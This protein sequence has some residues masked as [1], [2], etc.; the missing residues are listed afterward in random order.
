MINNEELTTKLNDLFIRTESQNN[1]TWKDSSFLSDLLYA[2]PNILLNDSFFTAIY[3]IVFIFGMHSDYYYGLIYAIIDASRRLHCTQMIAKMYEGVLQGIESVTKY[4]T[5]NV[6]RNINIA[7]KGVTELISQKENLLAGKLCLLLGKN[8]N[9]EK[10]DR[11]FYC[12]MAIR[13]LDE[14][15][16]EYET[17]V[18]LKNCF[19]KI[20]T[21]PC[22][23]I[24][25]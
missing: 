4:P 18:S 8:I 7:A 10:N 24:E 3:K 9:V 22:S 14:S 16:K 23:F 13:L 1:I 21:Y 2:S 11:I 15:S 25:N 19:K 12:E 17:A 20:C 6:D 5:V